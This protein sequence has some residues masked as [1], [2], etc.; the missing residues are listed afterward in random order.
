MDDHPHRAPTQRWQWSLVSAA[1]V[2]TDGKVRSCPPV[3]GVFVGLLLAVKERTSR[4]AG[5]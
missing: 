3:V 2:G 5:R 1:W 4:Q